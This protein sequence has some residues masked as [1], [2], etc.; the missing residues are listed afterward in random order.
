MYVIYDNSCTKI[1]YVKSTIVIETFRH[2][3]I[4]LS[5]DP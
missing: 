4:C 3:A 5:S 1:F 2:K